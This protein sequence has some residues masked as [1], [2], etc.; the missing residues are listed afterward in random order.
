MGNQPN[1]P[2]Q[3]QSPYSRRNNTGT[4]QQ[5][6]I[7]QRQAPLAVTDRFPTSSPSLVSR[8]DWTNFVNLK[9]KPSSSSIP[10]TSI[11]NDGASGEV[12]TIESNIRV[13]QN[14]SKPTRA[15]KVAEGRPPLQVLLDL[16]DTSHTKD[17]PAPFLPAALNDLLGLDFSSCQD[18]GENLLDK[19]PK[20]LDISESVALDC[21]TRTGSG[22]SYGPGKDSTSTTATHSNSIDDDYDSDNKDSHGNNNKS[23][24]CSDNN[25]NSNSNSNNNNNDELT[26]GEQNIISLQ[27]LEDL[28]DNLRMRCLVWSD[29]LE[30]VEL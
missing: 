12:K 3:S 19:E 5:R 8:Q 25:N 24:S 1:L 10:S 2:S 17:S 14:L 18:G 16:D 9:A 20:L 30:Q 27:K 22:L 15:V 23:S 28:R 13:S 4:M 11:P 21:N 26:D 6:T 7:R 29:L